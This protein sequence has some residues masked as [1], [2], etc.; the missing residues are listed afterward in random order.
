LIRGVRGRL[1]GLTTAAI[2]AVL[3]P[4][5]ATTATPDP[6]YAVQRAKLADAIAEEKR[7]LALLKKSPPR[8]R[9]AKLALERSAG[10][11]NEILESGP[12]PTGVAGSLGD[13]ARADSRAAH[14]IR[15]DLRPDSDAGRF[16]IAAAE[17]GTEA[18][19]D[20]KA[21]AASALAQPAAP[22]GNVQCAD[23]IDN[24]GDGLVDARFDSGCTSARDG[25]EQ[26]ALTCSLGYT[27]ETSVSLQGTCSGTFAKL[28]LNAP[29]GIA[30]DVRT[31][32]VV[33]HAQA[34][35]Y[36]TPRRL[37]CAMSD[38][39]ANPRHVVNARFRFTR[40]ARTALPVFVR[41]YRRR[42]RAFVAG[43]RQAS[44]YLRFRLSYTHTGRSHVCAS[45]VADSGALLKVK[46]EGP[47]GLVLEGTLQLK[48]K[49]TK[50]ATGSFSFAIN[51]FGTHRVTIVST[52]GGKTATRTE[53]IDVTGAPGDSRC[54][55]SGAP[56]PP[57]PPP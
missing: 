34:C 24:D 54:S 38:G 36:V 10:L 23:R 33:Q 19:L 12:L 14:D 3:L 51:E 1:L 40:P 21:W 43:R 45:I 11:L 6:K 29:V 48:K 46:L 57:P 27:G 49:E 20:Q 53:T 50:T 35:H 31:M 30:F 44:G 22:Q 25:G 42:A 9:T 7:A 2:V 28:E 15:R 16:A 26:G 4:S 17:L 41:D 18:A 47:N 5:A 39:V 37:E 8:T 52:V 56:P 13:A 55:A 32:P